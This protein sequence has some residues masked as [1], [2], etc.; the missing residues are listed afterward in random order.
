MAERRQPWL[1]LALA[2]ALPPGRDLR[3]RSRAYLGVVE[4]G[5]AVAF[6]LHLSLSMRVA[7]PASPLGQPLF[8]HLLLTQVK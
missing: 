3:R 4:A 5:S 8:L 2:L 1:D 7:S 6:S